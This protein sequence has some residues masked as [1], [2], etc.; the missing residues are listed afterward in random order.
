MSNASNQS[1]P[2]PTPSQEDPELLAE[3]EQRIS[4]GILIEP[5][6]WMPEAYRMG[7]L[8]MA[9]HHANSEIIGALPE[10]EWI[11]RAPSMRRKL[12]LTAKVQDEVGHGQ[13]LYRVSQEL[14]K[15]RDDMLR[16]L[17]TGK[18]KYHNCFNYPAPTWGDIAMIQWLIDGAAIMNQK[19]LA[20]G[21][22]GPYVRTMNRINMEEAFH[23]KSGEDM[24][25]TLMS[26]T[27]SQK[28]M[29]QDAFDRWWPVSLMFFG[30]ADKPDAESRPP[31]RWRMKIEKNDSLR[32]RFVNRFAPA[33]Q[34]LGLK[35]NIVTKD[36]KGNVTS[37]TPDE[38]LV[39]DEATGNW[40]FT[41]PDWDEFWRVIRGN[42]PCNHHRL[43]LRRFSYEQG[44]WVRKAVGSGAIST[45]PAA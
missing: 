5:G 43:S 7:M 28:Q 27:K 11:T 4:D 45:P 30:P 20:D 25:L 37:T 12:A 10:G 33:A 17:V 22:Y 41:Q 21:A 40:S 26:G 31:M 32:Q 14:G 1:K 18:T 34:D 42:G 38:E 3:F 29:T 24:V 6:D 44:V 23:F 9:E 13:M 36:D 15:S 35:I 19:T 8:A 39:L 16:D 2:V